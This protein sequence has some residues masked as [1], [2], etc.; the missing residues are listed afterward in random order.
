MNIN[1]SSLLPL[2]R[3]LTNSLNLQL[4]QIFRAVVES[5]DG[6]NLVLNING[7]K[8]PVQ[9]EAALEAGKTIFLQLDK[10]T[11][12]TVELK[13]V[14]APAVA[15]N[16]DQDSIAFRQ[17]KRMVAD[18]SGQAQN[19]D[20]DSIAFRPIDARPVDPKQ[21]FNQIDSK[22]MELQVKLEVVAR[23]C[24]LQPTETNLKII[25]NFMHLQLPLKKELIEQIAGETKGMPP[26]KIEAFLMTRSWAETT[27]LAN[28][29]DPIQT[30]VNFLLGDAEPADAANALKLINDSQTAVP[31]YYGLNCLWWQNEQQRGEI[32]LWSDEG[33]KQRQPISFG[34]MVIHCYTQNLG[35]LWLRLS[36]YG[37][38]LNILVQTETMEGQ[39]L[40]QENAQDLK[41]VLQG[42]GY[43]IEQVAYRLG[44]AQTFLELIEKKDT[45]YNEVDYQV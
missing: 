29:K 2:G 34:T 45:I 25:Q 8:I 43:K 35:E 20:Q 26:E 21:V 19:I 14:D 18:S 40:F 44:Q 39:Q 10:I 4:G 30:V 28:N 11:K 24:G 16:I 6:T 5:K 1:L 37:Q 15:Q 31:T 27:T 23:A 38:E 41:K 13:L 7:L 42:L 12:E 3:V 32:Y 36:R 22:Q 17:S 33:K 9:G